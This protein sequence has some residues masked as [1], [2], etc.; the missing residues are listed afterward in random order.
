MLCAICCGCCGFVLIVLC[1]ACAGGVCCCMGR[2]IGGSTGR[3]H[4]PVVLS[5][6]PVKTTWLFLSV[7]V[8][9]SALYTRVYPLLQNLLAAIKDEWERPGIM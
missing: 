9:D 1:R 2:G 8:H 7:T 5:H 6:F 3:C 4:S